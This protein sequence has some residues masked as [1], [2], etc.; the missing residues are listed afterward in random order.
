MHVHIRQPSY[1]IGL[2]SVL[3]FT[4]SFHP[5]FLIGLDVGLLA[6]VHSWFCMIY[7]PFSCKDESVRSSSLYKIKLQ[8]FSPAESAKVKASKH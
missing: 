7:P 6:F 4:S 5:R 8:G 3:G 1:F 2:L